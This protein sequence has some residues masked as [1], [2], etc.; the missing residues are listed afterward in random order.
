MKIFV[1]LYT[2][3]IKD[4]IVF[5]YLE[6]QETYESTLQEMGFVKNTQDISLDFEILVNQD[7]ISIAMK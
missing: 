1:T 2:R 4:Y 3:Q 6:C 7:S 5:V